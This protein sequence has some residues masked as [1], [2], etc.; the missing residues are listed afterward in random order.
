MIF[1][2]VGLPLNLSTEKNTPEVKNSARLRTPT[3]AFRSGI[4]AVNRA[5]IKITPKI[6]RWAKI[7]RGI[8]RKISQVG[9]CGHWKAKDRAIEIIAGGRLSMNCF[10]TKAIG[11]AALGK[12]NEDISP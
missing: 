9:P 6:S 12:E 4:K 8:M 11:R 2:A 7:Y 5:M 3:S 1:C 10:V